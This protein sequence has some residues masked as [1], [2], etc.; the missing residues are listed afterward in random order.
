MGG[1]SKRDAREVDPTTL[2]P[3]DNVLDVFRGLTARLLDTGDISASRSET[4]ATD[5]GGGPL[6][7]SARPA[8][9]AGAQRCRNGALGIA[10]EPLGPVEPVRALD[11]VLG[12]FW[13]S[14]RS[15]RHF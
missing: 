9:D 12:L 2:G 7:A 3:S 14:S 13:L 4:C 8:Q 5:I 15:R 6:L 11:D 10:D 1:G